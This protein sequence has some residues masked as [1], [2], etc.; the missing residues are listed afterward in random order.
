MPTASSI[1]STA[2]ALMQQ[3]DVQGMALAVIDRGQVSHVAA[4]GRRSA[5]SDGPLDTNTIM[6]GASLTKTA[7]AVLVLQ[8]VDEGRMALDTPLVRYLPKPISAY[9]DYQ[10]ISSDARINRVTARMVLSHTTGFANFRW[11]EPD[12]RLRFHHEPGKRYGYSGEGFYLLQLAIEEG[13]GI[14][15]G[16][17]M[18]TRIFD[19]IGM[20]RTSMMWRPDFR[21]NLADGFT[22]DGTHEPHD[23]RSAP[24]AAGS[25]DTDIADQARLWASI[26]RGDGLS[27]AS[28]AELVKPQV[29]ITSAQQFPTL[30]APEGQFHTTHHLAAGVGVVTYQDPR[31]L[32]FWKGGHNDSTGNIVVCIEAEQRCLVLLGNDVRAERVYPELVAAVLGPL[33]FPWSWE[34]GPKS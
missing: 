4:Y 10:D 17:A 14:E 12:E 2:K 19:R 7:A 18:Q 15:L 26:L 13:L 21:E 9:E 22:L 32:V 30:T 20:P 6:Y 27:P 29:A 28:R 23:E 3:Y 25:M 1:D 16:S 24:R 8:L 5:K 11:L 33:N 34:Y 31:G